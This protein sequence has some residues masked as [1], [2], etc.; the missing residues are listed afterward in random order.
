LEN[1]K[2]YLKIEEAI[3]QFFKKNKYLRLDLPVLSP[4]LIPESYLEV[5]ETKF[6]YFDKKQK[7]YLTPSPELF[8]KRLLTE[9]IGDCYYLGKSFRNAEA[10]SSLHFPEF[11]MLE[12]YKVGSDYNFM[13]KETSRLLLY[14]VNKVLKSKI[15][16]Y[17][18]KTIH[19]DQRW[20]E[21][22]LAEAFER[23]CQ[24]NAEDLFNKKNFFK[25]AE[26]RGYK[27]DKFTYVDLFSQIYVQEIEPNLGINGR[28]TIIFDYPKE[29]AALAKLNPDGK[30]AQRFEF[31][32][33]GIE[34]G[35]CYTELTDW[36]ANKTKFFEE[37]KQRRK[38]NKIKHT[39][40]WGFI[41]A[42]KKKMPKCSGIA[43]GIDRLAMIFADV[44]DINQLKLINIVL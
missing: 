17:R 38:D 39:I 4:A 18:G 34:L 30:T 15:I 7:L 3:H 16:T 26:K 9:K 20:E 1:Y 6:R 8:I 29:L 40:D 33:A 25:V 12:F 21:I 5:F 36:K 19:L 31:Y 14:I 23:F 22:S 13:K 43:I 24:I 27:T 10:S 35:N 32:I 42:L 44:F 28:P 41:N 11:T 37:E 2:T